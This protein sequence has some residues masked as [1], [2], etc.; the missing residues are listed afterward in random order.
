MYFEEEGYASVAGWKILQNSQTKHKSSLILW[1]ENVWETT[2]E[3]IP[4]L[5]SGFWFYSANL[6]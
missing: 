2:T 4:A 3:I 5:H 1:S 6:L